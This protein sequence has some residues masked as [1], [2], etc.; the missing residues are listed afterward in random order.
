MSRFHR[1]FADGSEKYS[2]FRP[3]YPPELYQRILSYGPAETN[4]AI[5]VATGNGQAAKHLAEHFNH[6]MAFDSSPEQ[7]SK[8]S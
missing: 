2:Q 1:L 7:V 6:V 3:T 5:D 4:L 8:V